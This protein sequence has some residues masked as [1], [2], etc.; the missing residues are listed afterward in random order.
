MSPQS[1]KSSSKDEIPERDVLSYLI[2]YLPLNYDTTVLPECFLSNAY[3]L[4]I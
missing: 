3:M 1:D 4:H 2:T